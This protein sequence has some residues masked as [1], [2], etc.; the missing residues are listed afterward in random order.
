VQVDI[1]GPA[2]R[3]EALLEEPESPKFIALVCHPHPLFGGSMHNHATYRLARAVREQGG[4]SLRFN[5]RGVGRSLGEFDDGRGEVEDAKAV[6]RWLAEQRPGL[7]TFLAGFS[8]GAHIALQV[9]CSDSM[10][11]GV[12]ASGLAPRSLR[13]DFV[14]HCTLPIAVVQADRDEFGSIDEVRFLLSGGA[15]PR[16]LWVVNGAAH[17]FVEALD[18]FQQTA[19][20]A[21]SWL[22]EA[23]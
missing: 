21:L 17:L 7:P 14:R 22:M 8:F 23:T 13:M 5:F 19:Q 9:G 15:G 16:R 4:S 6:L 2:G 20:E 12:L 3:V 1:P 10:V 18:S 11:A